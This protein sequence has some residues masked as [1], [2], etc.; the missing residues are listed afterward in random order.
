MAAR[1]SRHLEPQFLYVAPM[2]LDSWKMSPK[3][4]RGEQA[5]IRAPRSVVV[6]D[7]PTR[8]ISGRSRNSGD[9]Q[10]EGT[11][12][13]SRVTASPEDRT[14]AVRAAIHHE[15]RPASAE[16]DQAEPSVVD[17]A[18]RVLRYTPIIR[19]QTAKARPTR[20]RSRPTSKSGTR[21]LHSTSQHR[22]RVREITT[23]ERERRCRKPLP[24]P[25]PDATTSSA[26]REDAV[27]EAM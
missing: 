13:Q 1:L 24:D 9:V 19:L 12:A 18:G 5:T 23:R 27:P 20:H 6:R 17:A 22:W 8:Q 2:Q 3:M 16:R 7:F 11:R 15:D 21:E 14:I 25:A 10:R 26:Q 4:C